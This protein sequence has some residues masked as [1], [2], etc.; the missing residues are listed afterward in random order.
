MVDIILKSLNYDG[1]KKDSI[2]GFAKA[3]QNILD[4]I[5]NLKTGEIIKNAIVKSMSK[6]KQDENNQSNLKDFIIDVVMNPK[7]A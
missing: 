5:S 3:D 2:K 4:F 6:T 7:G 1:E